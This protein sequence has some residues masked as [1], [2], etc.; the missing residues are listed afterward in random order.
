MRSES[1]YHRDLG[2]IAEDHVGVVKHLFSIS[3]SY[4]PTTVRIGT[5][6]IKLFRYAVNNIFRSKVITLAL[7]QTGC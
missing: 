6:I 4:R 3:R 2:E 1:G 5:Q 7:K